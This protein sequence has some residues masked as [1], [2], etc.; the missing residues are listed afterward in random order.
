MIGHSFPGLDAH[1]ILEPLAYAVG[2][3]F[4]WRAAATRP[5]PVE[6]VDRVILLGGAVFGACLGSA[7]L[8]TLQHLPAIV[9]AHGALPWWSGKSVLGGFLGGTLGVEIAK[10]AIGWRLPTGDAWIVAMAAGLTIGRIGCQLT[11]FVDQTFGLPT[12]AAWGWDYGDGVARHPVALY[13]VALVVPLAAIVGSRALRRAPGAGFAAFLCGYCAI[14]FVL[15]FL[16]SPFGT[17]ASDNMPPGAL[18]VASYGG[19]SAIQWA[20]LGGI[21][22]YA[23]LMRLRLRGA[24]RGEG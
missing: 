9:A 16:Q 11:G 5:R 6:L 1:R 20:A 24:Y 19:L 2:A 3:R 21:V 10:R 18:A 8:H 14:R 12:G 13:E 22:W 7:L 4:Y 17:S 23:S 15:G